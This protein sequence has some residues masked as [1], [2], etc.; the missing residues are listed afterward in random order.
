MEFAK[1]NT[2]VL[3]VID[4]THDVKSFVLEK[5]SDFKYIAG[6]YC[7]VSFPDDEVKKPFTFSSSPTEDTI[8]ITIKV[9]GNF[10][11]KIFKA[12]VGD[13]LIIKGPFGEELNFDETVDKDVVFVAGGSGITPFISAIRYAYDKC[14]KNNLILIFANRTA[15]DIIFKEELCSCKIPI[16]H[17]LSAEEDPK[18]DLEYVPGRIN[19][20]YIQSHIE[21][22]SEKL[23]FLCGPPRMQD[24]VK[25]MLLECNI[26]PENI[27]I[28][29]WN[30][31]NKNEIDN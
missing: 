7:M 25:A 31:P 19:K 3:D 10:T 5:P 4:R 28:E 1:F 6:Q 15:Q 26:P 2:K 13:E 17:F 21:N 29:P 18:G 9:M 24:A 30:M 8:E 14:L 27:K 22:L 11:Q 12:Q 20:E 23:W 16:V